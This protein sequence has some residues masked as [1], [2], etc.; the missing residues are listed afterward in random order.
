MKLLFR[1]QAG[2]ET[3]LGHLR[4][5]ISLADALK[6]RGVEGNFLLHPDPRG[7]EVAERSG[8]S[9]SLLEGPAAFGEEDC[10]NT[11]EEARR[12]G[13]DALLFDYHDIPAEYIGSLR[14]AGRTLIVRDDLALRPL[15]VEVVVNGNADAERL[16]YPAWGGGARFLLGPRYAVL[17]KEYGDPAPRQTQ[18]RVGRVLV[19][20]GGADPRRRLPAL[21][22]RLDRLPES[23]EITAV[24]GPFF[25]DAEEVR[26]T[27]GRLRKKV[28]LV[29]APDSM[30]AL[31][32]GADLAVSAAGQTLYELACFGCP[33]VAF[34]VAENQQGQLA[35]LAEAGCILNAGR[36]EDQE[37]LGRVEELL[38]GLLRDRDRREEISR[39][40]QSLVDGRGADR[41]AQVIARQLSQPGRGLVRK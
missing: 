29:S 26:E 30:A 35:A 9:A 23:F 28:H 4:R 13:A 7:V 10:R 32:A 15:P 12:V 37:L 17:P 34:R 14:A 38:S 19:A 41:V 36:A 33:T 31:I 18:P 21:L 11:L 24:L 3:G 8:Y 2:P 6:R 22:E 5:S 25:D 16:G 27:A 20:L 40:G 39:A 1:V